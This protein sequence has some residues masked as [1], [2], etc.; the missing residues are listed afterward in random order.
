MAGFL[1]PKT[2][3]WRKENPTN[4][5]SLVCLR[6]PPPH[7]IACAVARLNK[8]MHEEDVH[9]LNNWNNR[10]EQQH[11]YSNKPVHSQFKQFLVFWSRL[12]CYCIGLLMDSL[13]MKQ[14]WPPTNGH[15]LWSLCLL[16]CTSVSARGNCNRLT[17]MEGICMAIV[18]HVGCVMMG[19]KE[20]RVR[21][22]V[23]NEILM[24]L[25]LPGLKLWQ[26][27]KMRDSQGEWF[28]DDAKL[29]KAMSQFSQVQKRQKNLLWSVGKSWLPPIDI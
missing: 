23:G 29:Y 2:I 3:P 19:D 28:A 6:N 7:S 20:S 21:F 12:G 17:R 1:E 9:K 15:G 13:W 24:V 5:S 22:S 27:V 26:Y 25:C 10:I 16:N 8:W 14:Q 18:H 4:L 11:H